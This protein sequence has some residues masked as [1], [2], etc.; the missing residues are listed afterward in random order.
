MWL[1]HACLS[2]AMSSN[3]AAADL[4]SDFRLPPGF[5]IQEYAGS[6]LANNIYCMTLDPQGRVVVSGPGY[7]KIL[8]EDPQTGRACR[9]IDFADGPKD[10]AQG[11]CWDGPWLYCNGEGGV[12]RYCAGKDRAEGPSELLRATKTGG[13][14]STHAIQ[15]GPDGWFYVLC[16]NNAGIDAS[17]ATLPTSPIQKPVAGCVL[18]FTPNWKHSEIVADGFRNP[19]GMDFSSNGELFTFDSDNERCVSLPWYESTRFYHVMEGGHYGWQSPQRAETWRFPP[20]FP[21]VI[22][23]VA[24][25]GRG[26]PTGVVC[27]RHVQ[28]PESYRGGFFLLDWTF[29]KVWFVTLQRFGSTFSCERKL[30]LESVGDNGFAP[31]AAVVHPA[32]G[33]VFISIGGRG[34]RGAV[35]RIRY[36]QAAAPIDRQALARLSIRPRSLG[37]Q[38]NLRDELLQIATGPD[39]LQRLRALAAIQRHRTRFDSRDLTAAIKANWDHVDRY[40]RLGAA[41]LLSLLEPSARRALVQDAAAPHAQLTCGLGSADTDVSA[42][43]RCATR[44]LTAKENDPDVRLASVR[45]IQLALGG[46]ISPKE[47]ATVWAGY[48]LHNADPS[49]VQNLPAETRTAL[50]AAFP[51]G[52][53][54]LDREITRT[55]A[56]IED[57]DTDLFI[58]V[59]QRVT[60]TSDP[61]DDIHYLIVLGRL[62]GPRQPALTKQIANALLRLDPKLTERHWNRDRNWPLRVR[63]LTAELA[64]KDP[65]LYAAML[66]DPAFGRPDHAMFARLPGFDRRKAAERFWARSKENSAF[67]WTPALVDIIASLPD[68]QW[69]PLLRKLWG[70][71]GLD[72]AI[73]PVLARHPHAADRDKFIEGLGSPQLATVHLSLDALD[74]LPRQ[75]DGPEILA[76][77][78]CLRSL[79]DGREE[80][81]VRARL[82]E[83]MKKLTGQEKLG[84]DKQAWTDWFT[85]SYP[86]LAARLGNADGVD[87]VGWTKRLDQ[88]DWSSGVPERGAAVFVKTNCA[89]CHSGTQALGPDLRGVASRFSRGDVF[90]AILQPSKD[91]SPRYRTTLIATE[92]GKVYQGLIVYEAVDSLIL[93]TGPVATVRIPVT[94]IAA[95]RFT[96]IS[97]MPPGLLDKLSDQEIV[98]LYAYLKSTR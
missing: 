77:V 78:R 67:V 35:Y 5:E 53:A 94:E 65:N 36:R 27:Y 33:D 6:S 39:P 70:K 71:A 43:L 46:L 16:G 64:R 22:A 86:S 17:Y 96:D 26:S 84:A 90:T 24:H 49:A 81:R 98:D 62:C 52:H 4:S 15:R 66:T 85:R 83:F 51:T 89:S 73:L 60:A 13:E 42:V 76:L 45:L 18:R 3:A 57:N 69:L 47:R 48:S 40:V 31:T 80:S 20:Y 10:G 7:I 75:V 9:A 91:I 72:D 8:I 63:E 97:L 41:R 28:F 1:Y 87:I 37:W 30:F 92:N 68:D 32:T 59:A 54:D 95:R 21:D 74:E 93:Q 11:L 23:P 14:H 34:T 25:M 38:P 88:L 82:A 56:A 19:Y 61:V 58:R 44:I 50:R 2:L 55:L 29:G 12:R 79:G